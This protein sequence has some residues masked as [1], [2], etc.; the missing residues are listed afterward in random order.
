MEHLEEVIGKSGKKRSET[1]KA[2]A[3]Q[4]M[5]SKEFK[6]SIFPIKTPTDLVGKPAHFCY[7]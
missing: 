6:V 3:G 5:L 1:E 7:I 2:V 4:G